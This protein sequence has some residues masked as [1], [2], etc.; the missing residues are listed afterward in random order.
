ME[1]ASLPAS[2]TIT[3][4]GM[5]SPACTQDETIVT[6]ITYGNVLQSVSL[7]NTDG[8]QGWGPGSTATAPPRWT[9]TWDPTSISGAAGTTAADHAYHI[10]N[11]TSAQEQSDV[12]VEGDQHVAYSVVNAASDAYNGARTEN[13]G[14][15]VSLTSLRNKTLPVPFQIDAT[16]ATTPNS[17]SLGWAIGFELQSSGSCL[18]GRDT[19]NDGTPNYLDLD[20]DN[21]GC[22]DAFEAGATTDESENYQFNDVAGDADGLS[23]TVDPAGDGTP[24]VSYTHLT[25]PTTPYV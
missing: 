21:D 24:A 8:W 18:L 19:D 20:S 22:S 16:A 1:L 4:T 15:T 12:T 6:A 13:D 5:N 3:F 25:L 2:G 14:L 11:Q 10:I 17:P 9:S 7:N 23:P